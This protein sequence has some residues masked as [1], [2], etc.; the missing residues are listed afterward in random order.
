MKTVLLKFK[1]PLQAWGTNSHFNIRRTDYYPSKSAVIGMI[2][3]ALGYKREDC[4]NDI[5]ILNNLNFAVRIDQTGNLMKDY[6]IARGKDTYL[7]ER[8]YIEDG[9]FLAALGSED[10]LLIEEIVKALTNSYFQTF[11]GRKSLPLTYDFLVGVYDKDVIEVL[12][13][14]NWEAAKWYKNKNKQEKYYSTRIYSDADLILEKRKFLRRDH[15]ISFSQKR[16]KFGFRYET[17]IPVQLLNTEY[18]ERTEHDAFKAL[19]G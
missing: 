9:V 19:G 13:N 17:S 16:R 11:M 8:Y 5:E 10:D 4:D 6:H 7:T 1:G 2:L 18:R 14:H 12:K 3:A 15:V